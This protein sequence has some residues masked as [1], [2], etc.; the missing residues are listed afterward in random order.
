MIVTWEKFGNFMKYP[1]MV[2]FSEDWNRNS[3]LKIKFTDFKKF[4]QEDFNGSLLKYNSLKHRDKSFTGFVSMGNNVFNFIKNGV[5]RY[6]QF[7]NEAE[8]FV[9]RSSVFVKDNFYLY[10]NF[11]GNK[12][13]L[14]PE[15]YFDCDDETE[16]IIA[17]K[18]M[19]DPDLIFVSRIG[20]FCENPRIKVVLRQSDSEC[21][22]LSFYSNKVSS[23]VVDVDISKDISSVVFEKDGKNFYNSEILNDIVYLNRVFGKLPVNPYSK[24]YLSNKDFEKGHN[25]NLDGKDLSYALRFII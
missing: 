14:L 17:E 9:S 23:T 1:D 6:I 25:I 24:L 16:K 11:K 12:V 19:R 22:Y 21:V 7:N 13:D 15:S 5:D 18:N 10:M 3:K 20:Y 2:Y 4:Y 8:N